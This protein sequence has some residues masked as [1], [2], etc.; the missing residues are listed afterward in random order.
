MKNYSFPEN[1]KVDPTAKKLISSILNLDPS[2]RPSLDAIAEHDFFKM[3]HSVPVLMPL[4]TLAC[5]PS[6]VYIS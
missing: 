1:I 6:Q 5:P 3:Y 4:S 2:K